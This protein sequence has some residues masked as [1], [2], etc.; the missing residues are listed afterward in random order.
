[1][2]EIIILCPYSYY[3][4]YRESIPSPFPNFRGYPHQLGFPDYVSV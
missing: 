4:M 2:N 1:M 3:R